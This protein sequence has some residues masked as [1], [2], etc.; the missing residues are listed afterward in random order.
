MKWQVGTVEDLLAFGVN[1]LTWADWRQQVGGMV[2]ASIR[3][4]WLVLMIW[5]AI[6]GLL[7]FTP[8]WLMLPL[9][10]VAVDVKRAFRIPHRDKWDVVL[11]A[12]LIP[13]ELFAWMRAA[14]FCTS[15]FEVLAG[16]VTGRR[17][18]HWML[19]YAAEGR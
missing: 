11:A 8:I 10:F 9:L 14:W 1:R 5:R 19:Q 18:D 17:K 2:A 7:V 13:Q 4:A 16:K 12:L 15:W 3:M 6:F